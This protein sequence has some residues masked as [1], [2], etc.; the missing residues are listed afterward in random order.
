MHDLEISAIL[1]LLVLIVILLCV[2]QRHRAAVAKK[3]A[4]IA[5]ICVFLFLFGD[6]IIG[7]IVMAASSCIEHLGKTGCFYLACASVF[8]VLLVWAGT[9]DYREN[10]EIK[11]GSVSAF[12]DRVETYVRDHKYSREKAIEITTRI[13]DGK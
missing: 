2:P 4:S 5:A 7:L 12:N 13:K 6:D 10:R 8:L 11:R 1:A 9:Q 3:Y